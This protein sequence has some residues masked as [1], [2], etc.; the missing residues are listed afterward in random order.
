[1][2][3]PTSSFDYIGVAQFGH[4]SIDKK[5]P[6]FGGLAPAFPAARVDP[7]TADAT[8]DRCMNSRRETS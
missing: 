6:F 5:F 8:M 4:G 7:T 3:S 1:M 2:E